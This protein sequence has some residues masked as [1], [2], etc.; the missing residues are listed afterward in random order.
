MRQTISGL[1]V[2]RRISNITRLSIFNSERQFNDSTRKIL[3]D[4][5]QLNSGEFVSRQLYSSIDKLV[6]I[7]L[8]LKSSLADL[9]LMSDWL[10]FKV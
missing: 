2:V 7:F 10:I 1:I 6:S 3:L 9:I 8:F 4:C 5:S